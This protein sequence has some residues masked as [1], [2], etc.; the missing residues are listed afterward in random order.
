MGMMNGAN[1]G[2]VDI[3]DARSGSH[4]AGKIV[5]ATAIRYFLEDYENVFPRP[6]SMPETVEEEMGDAWSEELFHEGKKH[7]CLTS[8]YRSFRLW[9]SQNQYAPKRPIYKPTYMRQC[10]NTYRFCESLPLRLW[11]FIC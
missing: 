3:L 6:N 11:C 9:R 2:N 4:P 1:F 10:L 7:S 5:R 8:R